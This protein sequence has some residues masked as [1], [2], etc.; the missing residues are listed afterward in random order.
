ML[1][2][3][4]CQL[5][6]LMPKEI[7]LL[8]GWIKKETTLHMC[9]ME[10]LVTFMLQQPLFNNRISLAKLNFKGMMVLANGAQEGSSYAIIKA[11]SSCGSIK[12]I[13]IKRELVKLEIGP[14]LF[15]N[16]FHTNQED[17]WRASGTIKDLRTKTKVGR[18]ANGVWNTLKIMVNLGQV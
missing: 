18:V 12:S 15:T 9:K 14:I 4:K 10:T 1:A 8:N 6:N 5:N 16:Q 17:L 13:K 11:R 7:K 2:M 3:E